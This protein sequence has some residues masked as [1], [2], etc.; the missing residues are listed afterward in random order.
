MERI[1]ES[2][3][4]RKKFC[5]GY[6]FYGNEEKAFAAMSKFA[7]HIFCED[8]S[9]CGTCYFCGLNKDNNPDFREI[10]QEKLGI[11][12]SR[13]LIDSVFKTSAYGGKKIYI[14]KIGHAMREAQNALLKILEEPPKNTYFLFYIR[15]FQNII[16]T[17]KSRMALVFCGAE[18]RP[19]IS[20]ENFLKMNLIEK[21]DFFV[22]FKE[23]EQ[24]KDFILSLI[25]ER[26]VSQ[27]AF[28]SVQE[29]KKME[30]GLKFIDENLPLSLVG[31]YIF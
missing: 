16:E 7:A 4:K 2:H 12:D 25:K 23:R 14:L 30:K 5:H 6:L 24:A 18:N 13:D 11:D 21:L 10:I 1:L 20:L 19:E 31:L 9:A 22:K 26:A 8:L 3:I 29:L 28:V 15:D 27:S 17:L